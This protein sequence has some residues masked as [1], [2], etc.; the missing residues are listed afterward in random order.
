MQLRE[1][2]LHGVL[3]IEP[4]PIDDE[5]GF[6][7][8]V[9]DRSVLAAHGIDTH[10]EQC[11]I[12]FNRR[13]GTVRGLHYQAAPWAESKLVRCTRG[14]IADVMADLRVSSPTFG[15]WISVELTAENR[16]AL[17]AAPGVAHGFQ[18]LVD[19]TEVYYQIS[20]AHR[21]DAA[22]GVRFNDP[23]FNI[24]WPIEVA[25]ISERDRAWPDFEETT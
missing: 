21:P 22:R 11:S 24:R 17:V 15:R 1:T 3:V 10:V 13:R 12:S 7:A 9:W 14:A 4:V 5:R 8:R 16:L 18:T 23:R 20:A 2:A 25:I 6:F 19:E